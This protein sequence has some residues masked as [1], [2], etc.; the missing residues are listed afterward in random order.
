MRLLIL[1]IICSVMPVTVACTSSL[2]H[3]PGGGTPP[4]LTAMQVKTVAH[5]AAAMHWPLK[6]HGKGDNP[7]MKTG[8]G[9]IVPNLPA[10]ARGA[11][12]GDM[13]PNRQQT[14]AIW[15]Y[16]YWLNDNATLVITTEHRRTGI[17]IT[18]SAVKIG[19]LH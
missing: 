11:S 5:A 2:S 7:I 3:R 16:Y 13:L 6:V 15:E 9:V 12:I 18:G 10:R 19:R 8:L 17:V 4:A 1:I 14:L